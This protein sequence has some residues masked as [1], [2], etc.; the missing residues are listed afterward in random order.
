MRN[1]VFWLVMTAVW[2]LI[3]ALAVY[4]KVYNM[5]YSQLDAEMTTE[6]VNE[7]DEAAIQ[8]M[9]VYYENNAYTSVNDLE[10]LE[11]EA[12]TSLDATVTLGSGQTRTVKAYVV[13]SDDTRYDWNGDT[14]KITLRR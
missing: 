13:Y 5:R 8:S 10:G 12:G 9:I 4:M 3:V 6:Y 14:V 11:I 2:M 1:K 7:L